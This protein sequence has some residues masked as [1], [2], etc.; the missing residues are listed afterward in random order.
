MTSDHLDRAAEAWRQVL[1][2]L[3]PEQTWIISGQPLERSE[4][5]SNAPANVGRENTGAGND[6]L[7]ALPDRHAP[8]PNRDALDQAA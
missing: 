2:E 5:T 1:T 8:T 6:N 4:L 3:H 7:R